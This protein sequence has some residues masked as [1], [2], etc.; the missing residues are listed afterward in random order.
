VEETALA[1]DGADVLDAEE[2][3]VS[4]LPRLVSS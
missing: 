2:E 1:V 4:V 3:A